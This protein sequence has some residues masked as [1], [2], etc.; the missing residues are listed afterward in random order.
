MAFR[1]RHDGACPT[2]K[3]GFRDGPPANADGAWPTAYA[4]GRRPKL[5]ARGGAFVATKS[6]SNERAYSAHMFVCIHRYIY[7]YMEWP[8]HV[9]T[10]PSAPS[11]TRG[12]LAGSH[13][14]HAPEVL[15]RHSEPHGITAR[16]QMPDGNKRSDGVTCRL[17]TGTCGVLSGYSQGTLTVLSVQASLG[18]LRGTLGPSRAAQGLPHGTQYS[19]WTGNQVRRTVRV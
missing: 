7:T 12:V 3:D 18:Y 9:G 17:P 13:G 10:R 11:R 15:K 1:S 5:R 8:A 2:E 4:A 19:V 14:T 16:T 6:P